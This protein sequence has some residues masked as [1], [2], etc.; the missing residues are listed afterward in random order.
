MNRYPLGNRGSEELH[1]YANYKAAVEESQARVDSCISEDKVSAAEEIANITYHRMT[2]LMDD[3]LIEVALQNEA[4]ELAEG[5]V[6][7]LYSGSN[8]QSEKVQK[9]ATGI[10]EVAMTMYLGKI[11]DFPEEGEKGKYRH[12]NDLIK[13]WLAGRDILENIQ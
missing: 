5:L 10:M 12:C 2:A 8:I 13:L 4:W 11:V 6:S 9:Y 7:L 3:G 1:V